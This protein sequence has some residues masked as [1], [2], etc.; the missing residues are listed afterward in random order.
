VR[1]L[2]GIG[3]HFLAGMYG[4][5][6][7]HNDL[8]TNSWKS[9]Y[10]GMPASSDANSLIRIGD[11]IFAGLSTKGV[12]KRALSEMDIPVPSTRIAMNSVTRTPIIMTQWGSILRFVGISSK[13]RAALTVF[14]LTG[15]RLQFSGRNDGTGVSFDCTMLHPGGYV[16]LL[17]T[18]DLRISGQFVVLK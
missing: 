10:D 13:P 6:V 11:T 9:V 7:Y 8:K 18:D 2:L 12:W 16:Y 17:S 1:T 14:S 15:K 3:N 4:W 5:P